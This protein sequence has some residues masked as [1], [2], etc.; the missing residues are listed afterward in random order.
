LEIVE[1]DLADRPSLA[2]AVND[3]CVVYHLAADYRLWV[4]DPSSLYQINVEGTK[5]L[6]REAADAGVE[7]IV[8]TSSVA[9]LG[10]NKDGTAADENTPVSAQDMVGHYKRSKYMAEERIRDLV[11]TEGLPVVIVNPSAPIGPGDIKPT[12]TGRMV[13]KAAQGA[14]PAFVDTGLNV[15]HVDDIATGHLLACE[16]GEVGE[17]YILGGENLTLAEIL[18][19][20]ARLIGRKPPKVKLPHSVLWPVAFMAESW[21]SLFPRKSRPTPGLSAAARCCRFQRCA[22]LVQRAGLLVLT[23]GPPRQRLAP[24]RFAPSLSVGTVDRPYSSHFKLWAVGGILCNQ[25]Q[26]T[27]RR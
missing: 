23:R 1:G 10:I 24:W 12:P 19:E 16:R 13:L 27:E 26:Q 9:T 6:M 8:Y 14:M 7:R 21:A 18:A 22:R 4:R 11:H 3:I 5:S 20:I 25:V 15:A 17:R 2:R